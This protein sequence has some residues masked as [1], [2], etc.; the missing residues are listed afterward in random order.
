LENPDFLF[1]FWFQIRMN[2]QEAH[3]HQEEKLLVSYVKSKSSAQKECRKSV[4]KV[5]RRGG[6][7][8]EVTNKSEQQIASLVSEQEVK[9]LCW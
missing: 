8:D 4:R 1:V 7:T 9:V 3:D 5:S 6:S 2:Q